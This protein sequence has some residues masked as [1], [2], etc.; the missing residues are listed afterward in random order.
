MRRDYETLVGKPYGKN[1]VRYLDVN[2]C[3]ILKC[4]LLVTGRKSGYGIQLVENGTQ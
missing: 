2:E 1:H 3:I 4:I